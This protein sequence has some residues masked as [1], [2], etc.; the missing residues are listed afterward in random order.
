MKENYLE[1]F[2]KWFMPDN[3]NLSK[4]KEITEQGLPEPTN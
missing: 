3:T 2:R 1:I 4:A